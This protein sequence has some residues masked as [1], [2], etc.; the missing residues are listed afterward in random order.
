M[1][2]LRYSVSIFI[3]TFSV[4]RRLCKHSSR[5]RREWRWSTIPLVVVVDTLPRKNIK[6][7]ADGCRW[8]ESRTVTMLM[9]KRKYKNIKSFMYHRMFANVSWNIWTDINR[10]ASGRDKFYFILT[11]ILG[12]Q[13]VTVSDFLDSKTNSQ[14]I[15]QKMSLWYVAV[16]TM[17]G[18]RNVRNLDYLIANRINLRFLRIS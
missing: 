10:A 7:I 1:R 18:M 13:M 5:P 17:K 14:V 9:S 3:E 11:M 8:F 4:E 2:Q 15:Y 12:S 6:Q 16:S